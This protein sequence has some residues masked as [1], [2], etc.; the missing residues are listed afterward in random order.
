MLQ[1]EMDANTNLW[2]V[3]LQSG[4][5]IRRGVRGGLLLPALLRLLREAPCL[6]RPDMIHLLFWN[7][8]WHSFRR[9]NEHFRQ[10]IFFSFVPCSNDYLNSPDV[11]LATCQRCFGLLVNGKSYFISSRK[12]QGDNL[13]TRTE[14]AAHSKRTTSNSTF[15]CHPVESCTFTLL[16]MQMV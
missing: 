1:E 13:Y 6:R 9:P 10:Q 11:Y 16:V 14:K 5:R 2:L 7:F 4:C 15:S 12:I 3:V 8:V